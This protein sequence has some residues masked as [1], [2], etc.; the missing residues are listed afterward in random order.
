MEIL[1][2]API[3]LAV[4]LLLVSPSILVSSASRADTYMG[5]GVAAWSERLADPD[6]D[7]RAG[8]A[9]ALGRIGPSASPATRALTDATRDPDPQV[10]HEASEAL[11]RIVV[12]SMAPAPARAV[13]PV[14]RTPESPPPEPAPARAAA[15]APAPAKRPDHRWPPELGEPYPDLRLLDHTGRRVRLSD[16]RGSVILVEPIGM[17]CPGCN[18]FVGG[19][20][21]GVGGFQGVRPQKGLPAVED[22]FEKYAGGV[23]FDDPRLVHVQLILYDMR[24]K[25]PYREAV[26]HWVE[27]FDVPV[28]PRHV[29]LLGEEY[30]IG[31]ASYD[32]IPGYQLVDKDFVL[33]Y[34]AA[35]HGPPHNLWRDL[36]PAVKE[37]VED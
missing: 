3:R 14:A 4:V 10:R 17:T 19:N 30:L 37:L 11:K 29:V 5:K 26:R 28:G 23:A 21:P 2:R 15:P 36:L 35:G 13:A 34:D 18:A 27:H 7:V 9:Y 12:P 8:A 1:R 32:L 22:V 33:R 6:P 24:M 16:F 20:R 31:K 25:A